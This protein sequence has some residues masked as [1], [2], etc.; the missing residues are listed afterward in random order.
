MNKKIF[1]LLIILL[2]SVANS[3]K[4]TTEFIGSFDLVCDKYIG[5]DTLGDFY[6]IKDNVFTK[7][8]KTKKWEYK[9]VA[10]GKISSVDIMN[11]LQ[12]ILFYE[13]FNTVILLDN[14]LNEVQRIEFSKLETSIIA[15]NVA[16]SSRNKL[17]VYNTI[18]QRLGLFNFL[19]NT[20]NEFPIPVQGTIKYSQTNFNLFYWID[21]INNWYSC[22]IFGKTTLIANIPAYDF[23]QIIDNERLLFS[24]ENKLFLLNN[25][26]KTIIEI[27]IVENSFENFYYKDQNL[28]IFTDQQ[29]RNYK[30]KL[31]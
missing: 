27:E 6:F 12:I 25:T 19:K 16:L 31:P 24:K 2:T 11:P 13:P 5:F 14:Q 28:A 8:S 15:S 22:D 17:W 3:Q 20:I 23:I 21:D 4:L 29:I 7:N 18:N 10:L 30:I 26:T 1:I 9:N